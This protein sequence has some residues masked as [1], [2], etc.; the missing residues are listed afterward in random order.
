MLNYNSSFLL[1]ITKII[2]NIS[3]KLYCAS[4]K[5]NIVSFPRTL[6]PGLYCIE[7][8]EGLIVSPDPQ[9]H[10]TSQFM[11]NTRFFS[12]LANTLLDVMCIFN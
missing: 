10:F 2:L 1:D 11:Q 8:S 9:L 5:L 6:P 12:F 7:P 3:K 4:L